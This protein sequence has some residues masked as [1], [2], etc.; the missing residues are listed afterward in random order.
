MSGSYPDAP[1]RRMAWDED[2]TIFWTALSTASTHTSSI[3]PGLE[4]D[5]TEK[6]YY[7]NERTL[8]SM[9]YIN[10]NPGVSGGKRVEM[11]M[12]FPE[13]RD[14]YG[15]NYW[16]TNTPLVIEDTNGQNKPFDVEYSA[17][18]PNGISG[19][20]VSLYSGI[21]Y[22]VTAPYQVYSWDHWYRIGIVSDAPFPITGVRTFRWMT[23]VGEG[24]LGSGAFHHIHLY[25]DKSAG[26]TPDRLL[27]ID[28][29][30]G[31]EF[32]GPLDWGDVPRGTTLHHEIKVYNNS[33]TLTANDIDLDF[34][35]LTGPSDTWHTISDSGGAFGGTANIVSLAP[36]SYYPAA[37]V[38]TVKLT[39][40]VAESLGPQACRLQA[41]TASW[42]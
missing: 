36:L 13:L 7:N 19:T 25:G 17:D 28:N 15:M 21:T 38:Y 20:W 14:I 18:S 34:E 10:I 41:V 37:D 4:R 42:T 5:A 6:G 16:T 8:T 32:T 35:A 2:G 1:F 26:A 23:G 40:D 39:V 27:F 3:L 22:P 24:L 12:I 31:L 9:E 33:A 29:D 11:V 30:T